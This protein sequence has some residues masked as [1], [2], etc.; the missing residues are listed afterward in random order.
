MY[1]RSTAYFAFTYN[2]SFTSID[3]H[4]ESH[5]VSLGKSSLRDIR[6]RTGRRD[7][8]TEPAAC[9]LLGTG[10]IWDDVYTRLTVR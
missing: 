8:S 2:G 1:P 5:T 7:D 6:S 9:Y 3:V 4:P 10:L